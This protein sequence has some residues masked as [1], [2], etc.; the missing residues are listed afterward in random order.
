MWH[1]YTRSNACWDVAAVASALYIDS[2][3]HS[4]C[5]IRSRWGYSGEGGGGDSTRGEGGTSLAKA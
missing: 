5:C 4:I 2:T 1:T 3:E